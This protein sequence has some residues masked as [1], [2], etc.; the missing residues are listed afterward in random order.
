MKVK[1]KIIEGWML[2]SKG[3]KLLVDITQKPW[4][5]DMRYRCEEK[6]TDLSTAEIIFAGYRE[7]DG[8]K[9]GLAFYRMPIYV[10]FH[11]FKKCDYR[12]GYV[13]RWGEPTDAQ[14]GVP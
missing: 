4:G 12:R 8:W 3:K 10:R 1:L 14:H 2:A 13:D 11:N 7:A 6:L 9:D 5:D